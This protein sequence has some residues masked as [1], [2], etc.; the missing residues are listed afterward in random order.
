MQTS[1]FVPHFRGKVIEATLSP[2]MGC[3]HSVKLVA[4]RFSYIY[5]SCS[6]VSSIW[7]IPPETW[8]GNLWKSRKKEAGLSNRQI[9]VAKTHEPDPTHVAQL[10]ESRLSEIPPLQKK[11]TRISRFFRHFR[12]ETGSAQDWREENDKIVLIRPSFSSTI[13]FQSNFV[14]FLWQKGWISAFLSIW[15][16]IVTTRRVVYRNELHSGYFYS[17]EYV[18][19]L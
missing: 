17:K 19:A 1:L 11:A 3:E 2:Q 15:Q 5:Q 16:T 14:P 4:Q 12:D 8:Q 6:I 9:C 13:C 10:A 18:T 7:T